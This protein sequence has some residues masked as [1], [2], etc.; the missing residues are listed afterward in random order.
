[1]FVNQFIEYTYVP[2]ILFGAGIV[3]AVLAV[4]S[5][6]LAPIYARGRANGAKTLG[7]V[8]SIVSFILGI[9]LIIAFAAVTVLIITGYDFVTNISGATQTAAA[10]IFHSFCL[11]PVRFGMPI[12]IVNG[13]IEL[14]ALLP[15]AFYALYLVVPA[16]LAFIAFGVSC[17]CRKKFAAARAAAQ[18]DMPKQPLQNSRAVPPVMN[19]TTYTYSQQNP[20]I[21]ESSSS[22]SSAVNAAQPDAVPAQTAVANSQPV[23]EPAQNA[24]ANAQPDAEPVHTASDNAQL[25]PEPFAVEAASTDAVAVQNATADS[26][27]A[28]TVCGAQLGGAQACAECGYPASDGS[29]EKTAEENSQPQ[30]VEEAVPAAVSE[31]QQPSDLQAVTEEPTE[32]DEVAPEEM[33][34]TEENGKAAEAVA[35][36]DSGSTENPTE[37]IADVKSD[38]PAPIDS[39]NAEPA[40][41]KAVQRASFCIKCGH[42]LGGAAFCTNCGAPA[43]NAVAPRFCTGCGA[44]VRA[45][46]KFCTLC[47]QEIK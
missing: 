2:Y 47:G 46:A 15:V 8:F 6:I 24:T 19:V 31:A 23:A 28:C 20:Q 45:D 37:A 17:S 14:S 25:Q 38:D 40:A 5:L 10:A 16:I 26:K 1:M 21:N 30:S 4:I 9:L 7:A 44:A 41:N 22:A 36:S 13:A 18:S 33:N 42:P 12:T 27:T 35:L 43:A 11:A 39:G 29:T 32:S 3:V 34:N